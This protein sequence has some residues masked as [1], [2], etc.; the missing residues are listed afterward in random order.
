VVT[1]VRP[2]APETIARAVR[3][4]AASLVGRGA[5]A[6]VIEVADGTGAEVAGPL[7]DRV[8][9]AAAACLEPPRSL[10]VTGGATLHHLVG[11]LGARSLLVNGEPLPGVPRSELQGGLWDGAVVV[12][13]SGAFGDPS[14]LIRLVES[15]M[16]GN[17]E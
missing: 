2:T 17:H 3:K 6:L 7:F 9:S 15:A 14:L 12:S 11:V 4:V 16:G 1:R 10:V 13:K 5:A 8:L